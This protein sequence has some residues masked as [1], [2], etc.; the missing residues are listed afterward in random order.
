MERTRTTF[1]CTKLKELDQSVQKYCFPSSSM[2][3]FDVLVAIVV[4]VPL[5][6]KDRISTVKR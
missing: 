6:D 1:K 5:V 2:Q 3:L 4:L